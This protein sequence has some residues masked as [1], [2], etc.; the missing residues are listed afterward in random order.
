MAWIDLQDLPVPSGSSATHLETN[1]PYLV[2]EI[3]MCGVFSC[4]YACRLFADLWS[5]RHSCPGTVGG[6]KT[7]SG[8]SYG[9]EPVGLRS[10]VA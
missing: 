1:L 10:R 9:G 2:F 7:H 6:T 8:T 3:V 4:V 5:G